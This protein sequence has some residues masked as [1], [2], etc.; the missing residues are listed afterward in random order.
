MSNLY[1][2]ERCQ[3]RMHWRNLPTHAC[4]PS[5]YGLSLEAL[6]DRDTVS[7]IPGLVC[8]CGDTIRQ[9]GRRGRDRNGHTCSIWTGWP[10]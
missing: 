5:S 3:L 2:C 8:R 6:D 4:A 1:K 9:A 10:F 7:S